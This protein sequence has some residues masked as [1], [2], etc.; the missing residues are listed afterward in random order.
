MAVD[1][2]FGQP[3]NRA[4]SPDIMI[5][6]TDGHDKSNVTGAQRLAASKNI[7]IFSV[8][9]GS[10]IHFLLQKNVDLKIF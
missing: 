2:V 5:V 4:N 7:T 3:G 1:E 8:G 10:G 6:I 9:I